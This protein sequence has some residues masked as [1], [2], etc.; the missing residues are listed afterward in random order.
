V[1]VEKRGE[2]KKL[3]NGF[4]ERKKEILALLRFTLYRIRNLREKAKKGYLGKQKRFGDLKGNPNGKATR[5]LQGTILGY[6]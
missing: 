5:L 4:T 6:Y 2:R 1:L 3:R